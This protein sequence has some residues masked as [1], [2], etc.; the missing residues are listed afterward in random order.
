[1]FHILVSSAT[2]GG[3]TFKKETPET[4]F[5]LLPSFWRGMKV[6]KRKAIVELIDDPTSLWDATLVAT[7]QT[8][9]SLTLQNISKLLLCHRISKEEP[10]SL[11]LECPLPPPV[12]EEEPVL[13]KPVTHG[14]DSFIAILP[15]LPPIEKF[16]H[17]CSFVRRNLP[18]GVVEVSPQGYVAV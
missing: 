6:E 2:T 12:V 7:L 11:E 1:M 16:D 18:A 13:L 3:L 17:L 10:A 15:D 8:E 9:Y 4:K 14:L 5:D